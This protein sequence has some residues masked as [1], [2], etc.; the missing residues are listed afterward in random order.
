MGPAR[1][2][3]EAGVVP[4][5]PPPPHKRSGFLGPFSPA[6]SPNVPA[7]AKARPRSCQPFSNSQIINLINRHAQVVAM[8]GGKAREYPTATTGLIRGKQRHS[9]TDEKGPY[10]RHKPCDAAAAP[11]LSVFQLSIFAVGVGVG[12]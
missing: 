12:V 3:G 10:T 8:G 4:A 2:D 11:N 5:I 1:Q 9:L 7:G 6:S